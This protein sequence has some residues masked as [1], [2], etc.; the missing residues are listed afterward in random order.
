M[1]TWANAPRS[2]GV[3]ELSHLVIYEN[4]RAQPLPPVFRVP[5]HH[6]GGGASAAVVV[7]RA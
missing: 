3:A 7:A 6:G 4:R 2:R 1:A 5:V